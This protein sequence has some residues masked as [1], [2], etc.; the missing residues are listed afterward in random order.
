M[1]NKEE[2]I[3]EIK[4]LVEDSGSEGVIVRLKGNIESSVLAILAKE[5]LPNQLTTLMIGI[6]ATQAK[7]RNGLRIV[8][9]ISPEDVRIT[10]DEEYEALIK[11]VFERKDIYKDPETYNKYLKTG[12]APTD[13]S[14]LEEET[15]SLIREKIKEDLIETTIESWSMRRNYIVL[16]GLESVNKEQ[17]VEIAKE[18]NVPELVI[19]TGE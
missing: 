14:Y 13:S 8:E 6:G 9:M 11:R 12:E 16:D 1:F 18:L 15:H 7:W 3:K 4:K 10:L 2:A 17:L 19:K 5:A